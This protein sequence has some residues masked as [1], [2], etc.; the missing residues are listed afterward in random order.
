LRVP[1]LGGLLRLPWARAALQWPVLAV[2]V[3]LIY[4][5]FTGPQVAPRNLA[6]VV[7]WVCSPSVSG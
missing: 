3:L 2:A 7:Q 5:G 1:F 4:E 6:G